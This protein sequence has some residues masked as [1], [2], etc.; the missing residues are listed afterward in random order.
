MAATRS[1]P[2]GSWGREYTISTWAVTL[3]RFAGGPGV[4]DGYL[5]PISI[6]CDAQLL[7]DWYLP[8]QGQREPVAAKA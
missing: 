5:A 4:A 6:R 7:A 3:R 1:P 2:P 8:R